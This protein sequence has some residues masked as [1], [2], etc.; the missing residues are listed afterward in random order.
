MASES[1]ESGQSIWVQGV[2]GC[3]ELEERQLLA[4]GIQQL[5]PLFKAVGPQGGL[6]RGEEAGQAR[7]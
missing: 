1:G 7:F 4:L 2:R 6:Q 3:S 5:F